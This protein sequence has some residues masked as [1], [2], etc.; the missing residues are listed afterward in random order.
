MP[1]RILDVDL[2]QNI[3][4][5]STVRYLIGAKEIVYPSLSLQTSG[6]NDKAFANAVKI[7]GQKSGDTIFESVS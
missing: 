3:Y 6:T 5:D 7:I 4:Y 1:R 2:T